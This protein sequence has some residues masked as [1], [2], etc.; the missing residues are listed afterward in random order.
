MFIFVGVAS[1]DVGFQ[2]SLHRNVCEANHYQS[3][4]FLTVKHFSMKR[5]LSYAAAAATLLFFSCSSEEDTTPTTPG[6]PNVKT[7]AITGVTGTTALSGGEITEAGDTPITAKGICWSTNNPPTL[8]DEYTIDGSGAANFSSAM[9]DLLP[10]TKYYVR[11]YATN[12]VGTSFG[13]TLSFTTDEVSAPPLVATADVSANNVKQISAKVG[14]QLTNAQGSSIQE[15]GICYMEDLGNGAEPTLDDKFT[16]SSVTSGAFEVVL[17]GFE[18]E[19]F[20]IKPQTTYKYRA[21]AKN[22]DGQVGY[23]LTKTFTTR[24]KVIQGPTCTDASGNTYTTVILADRIWTK[25]NMRT[26]IFRDNSA[27]V[28]PTSGN[29]SW[30]GNL[31]TN[32]S[33]YTF[34]G[35]A[36]SN[37]NVH[38]LLYNAYAAF[39]PNNLL[40]LQSSAN[41]NWRLPSETDYQVLI[42]YFGGSGQAGKK[43]K[44]SG[45]WSGG[46]NFADNESTFGAVASGYRDDNGAFGGFQQSGYLWINNSTTLKAVELLSTANTASIVAIPNAVYG[47]SVRCVRDYQP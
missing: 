6:A 11:A 34:P 1:Q 19:A 45:S 47:L 31:N 18:N 10:S 35:G 21:Y 8:A 16:P 14:G 5:F 27:T 9:S 3:K 42:N 41:T 24:N 33:R 20:N 22:I 36:Q 32:P 2:M 7:V 46:A 23:G 30:W 4:G 28:T 37:V 12:S 40:P 29:S 38:G 15:M 26:T 25:E 44:V 17:E 43:L 39:D 13:N